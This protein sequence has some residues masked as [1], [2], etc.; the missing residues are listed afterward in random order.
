MVL[1][2]G[3]AGGASPSKAAAK[4]ATAAAAAARERRSLSL[5]VVLE[6]AR[7]RLEVSHELQSVV[8][9]CQWFDADLLGPG[10][11]QAGHATQQGP[12]KLVLA[13]SAQLSAVRKL[14]SK[15]ILHVTWR[16]AGGAWW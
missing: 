10:L 4:R 1:Q 7:S 3:A 6:R 5:A 12:H 15:L 8:S 13:L 9:G 11:L 2:A 14:G 16:V